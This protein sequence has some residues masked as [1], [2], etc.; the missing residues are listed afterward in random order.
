AHRYQLLPFLAMLFIATIPIAMPSSFAVANSVEARELS[1]KRILVSELTGIQEAANL[2][3]LLVDKTGT[4]TT[5]QPQVV[6]FKNLS[7]RS[8]Q[9]LLRL[10]ARANEAREPRVGHEASGSVAQPYQL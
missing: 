8:D 3:L 6:Q 10:A 4:I 9:Q 1:R 2:N 5:N 7:A